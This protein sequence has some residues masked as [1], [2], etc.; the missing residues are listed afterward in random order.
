MLSGEA[1]AEAETEVTGAAGR[2]WAPE[3]RVEAYDCFPLGE[4][5]IGMASCTA[6][7]S[8]WVLTLFRTGFSR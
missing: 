6:I 5:A 8:S 7:A 4:G 1:E 3:A 2:G